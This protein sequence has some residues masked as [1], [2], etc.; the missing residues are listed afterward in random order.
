MRKPPETLD[1]F[2]ALQR[3]L[4]QGP[5]P[6]AML[7]HQS[8]K[9]LHGPRLHIQDLRVHQRKQQ[10]RTMIGNHPAVPL[11]RHRLECKRLGMQITR[12]T[13]NLAPPKGTSKHIK[14]QHQRHRSTTF[15]MPTV[16][17]VP[18][19]RLHRRTEPRRK[20]RNRPIVRINPSFTLSRRQRLRP[21]IQYIRRP[22]RGHEVQFA[23]LTDT[24]VG[25]GPS[26]HRAGTQV[27]PGPHPHQAKHLDPPKPGP[28]QAPPPQH[29]PPLRP[30]P[31]PHSPPRAA[32]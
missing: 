17:V 11:H 8:R 6:I 7:L 20:P 14:Q 32:H 28:N 5:V 24:F 12:Q 18:Q 30:D 29:G 25:S 2:L 1:D 19:R 9:P 22:Q 4:Q 26:E 23:A 13:P 15:T 27:P 3:M 21:R 31:A 16:Q 10:N